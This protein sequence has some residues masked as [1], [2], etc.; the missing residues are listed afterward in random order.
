MIKN[1]RQYALTKK[2]LDNFYSSLEEV[3]KNPP[4]DKALDPLFQKV[5]AAA[6]M[7]QISDLKAELQEYEVLLRGDVKTFECSSLAELPSLLIKARISLGLSQKDL[8]EKLGLKEQQ[9]QRYE[10]TDYEAASL[11]RLLEISDALGLKFTQKVELPG[12]MTL[13]DFLKRASTAGLPQD[14]ILKKLVPRD[15]KSKI[16]AEVE[17][18]EESLSIGKIADILSRVFQWKPS[19]IFGVGPLS[20]QA[21]LAPSFKM[22]KKRDADFAKAYTA[23]A[24]YLSLVTVDLVSDF[25]MNE[26]PSDPLYVREEVTSKT[27]GFTLRNLLNFIWDLGIPVLPLNDSGAF[28]GA[29]WRINRR[30][31][32]VV[33]QKSPYEARW[34]FDLA[35]ELFHASEEPSEAS[36]S[37]VDVFED[38]PDYSESEEEVS[39]SNYAGILTLGKN[40]EKYVKECVD[41]AT[42]RVEL[43]QSTVI[44]VAKLHN[45]DTGLLANFLAFRLSLQGVNWWGAAANLQSE[46][47]NPWITARDIFMER[48]DVSQINEIDRELILAAM[49]N[50][51]G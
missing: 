50:E 33:K 9:I 49:T 31:I 8:A 20:I 11:S 47:K 40:A 35:H 16:K 6:I 5:H 23:Y 2:Q 48:V 38:Y 18:R 15:V 43:F 22:P 12:E 28:H 3:K 34:I 51:E 29:C 25:P 39:A 24:H 27:S 32:I 10:A 17:E 30:N 36:R 14:F 44:K 45:I 26:V 7:G 21:E 46:S 37:V 42:G 41:G 13:S 1:N 4:V 19:E